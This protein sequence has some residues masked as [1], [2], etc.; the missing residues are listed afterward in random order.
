[1]SIVRRGR[2]RPLNQKIDL[3][4]VSTKRIIGRT[5]KNA[6]RN[7]LRQARNFS[8]QQWGAAAFSYTLEVSTYGSSD[9]QL[10]E[11]VI[12]LTSGVMVKRGE[13][14]AAPR[15]ALAADSGQCRA[16]PQHRSGGR[17]APAGPRRRHQAS[18]VPVLGVGVEAAG[19]MRA[20]WA[21]RAR[22]GRE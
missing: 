22:C 9:D 20:R 13:L 5:T 1:M 14:G 6:S 11:E 4:A 19:A 10:T 8:Y 3:L 12:G 2:K 21:G 18:T 15:R 7:K 16:G 17:A